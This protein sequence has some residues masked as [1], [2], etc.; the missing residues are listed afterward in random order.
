MT[1]KVGINGFGRIGRNI[2]RAATELNAE[3][4]DRRR[5]RHRRRAHLRAPAEARHGPRHVR[6][7]GQRGGRRPITVGGPHGQVPE[8]PGPRRAAAG[9]TS[10]STSSIEST[11]LFTDAEKARVHIDKGGANEGDHL[12][13]GDQPGLHGRDG[14]QP[15]GL[16]RR[17]KH[18]SSPTAAAR[19]TAWCRSP[20]C[21]TTA[22]ASSAGMMTTI[23]AYTADQKLQDL[24]AQGPAAGAGGGR[25]HHPDLDRRQPRRGRGAAGAGRASSRAWPSG[26]RSSTS[27]SST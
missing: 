9:R 6:A 3:I 26:C 4:R 19:P 17:R 24:P 20:R 5:Q 11:G 23:H 22:S 13:P 7:A 1:I 12:R 15:R 18:M 14:R 10:A 8:R 16:R 27:R 21:S 2:Y 25:Q